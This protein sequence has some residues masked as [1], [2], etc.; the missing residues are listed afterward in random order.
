[1]KTSINGKRKGDHVWAAEAM[2]GRE[3]L[4]GEVVHHIDGD[5][6]NNNHDNLMVFPDHKSHYEHHRQLRNNAVAIEDRYY[7]VKNPIQHAGV[8]LGLRAWS[9]FYGVN[10]SILK[11]HYKKGIP[12]RIALKRA[13]HKSG[14]MRFTEPL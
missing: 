11:Y 12:F 1:M 14:A 2:L 10:Y 9:D 13:L 6:L 7:K 5:K 8:S 3:L 4:P